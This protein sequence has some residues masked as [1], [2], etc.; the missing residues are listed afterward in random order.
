MTYLLDANVL[1][2]LMDLDHI[3]YD[4]AQSWF[5]HTGSQSWA[6]CPI[7]QLAAL[8]IMGGQGYPHQPDGPA[9]IA[10]LLAEFCLHRGHQ[11]W[12][13]A[14]SLVES[15]H[16][17]ITKLANA[18]HLTDTYLL[19]LAVQRGGQLATF[20]RRIATAA[21]HDG[22]RHLHIIGG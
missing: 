9:R 8:R 11:F 7:T 15:D 22:P 14:V 16:V 6:T 5:Q 12:P 19:A 2:A 1:I 10:Q 18:K 4:S 3:H 17:N 20:D 13:D 21:V